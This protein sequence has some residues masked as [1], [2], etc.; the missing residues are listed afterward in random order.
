MASAGDS[1]YDARSSVEVIAEGQDYVDLTITPLDVKKKRTVRIPLEGFPD[2][3]DRTTRLG[4]SVGFLD[5]N[6]M[7]V[8][9]EDKG[10]R[11][12]FPATDA[13]VRREVR[14]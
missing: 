10:F 2:R 5:E 1:W 6:T 8:A 13:V 7:A 14:M 9:I 11:E 12:L 4:V 3:P